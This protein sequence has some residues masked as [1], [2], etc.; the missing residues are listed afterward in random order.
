MK[1]DLS[2]NGLDF[3]QRLV[4]IQESVQ[5]YPRQISTV[6]ASAVYKLDS[7]SSCETAG[8]VLLD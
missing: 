1:Y 8:K 3:G 2:D 5:P 6:E 7:L 4:G